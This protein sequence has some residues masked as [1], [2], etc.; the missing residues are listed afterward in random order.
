MRSMTTTLAIGIFALA[1]SDAD[2][3]VRAIDAQAPVKLEEI[4]LAITGRTNVT[5]WIA[6]RDNFVAVAWGASQ[7]GA[8]DS[9][10]RHRDGGRRF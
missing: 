7:K 1:L 9:S 3:R 5:P 2:G 10:R 8:G 4:T 6:G